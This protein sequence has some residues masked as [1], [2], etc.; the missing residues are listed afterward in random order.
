MTNCAV[1]AGEGR[2]GHAPDRDLEAFEP[3]LALRHRVD[4]EPGQ[5]GLRRRLAG[6]ELDPTARHEVEHGHTLGRAGRVVVAG[7]CS[8]YIP[9]SGISKGLTLLTKSFNLKGYTIRGG[10]STLISHR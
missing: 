5:L 4:L 3:R 1:D 9:R 8:K 10:E 2:L 6:A 7:L